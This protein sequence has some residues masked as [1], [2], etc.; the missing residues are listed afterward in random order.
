MW[1]ILLPDHS[2]KPATME[3]ANAQLAEW[4]KL[5]TY[6]QGHPKV[7]GKTDIGEIEV[8]TV[9]LMMDHNFMDEGPPL[10]FETMVF[11][12]PEEGDGYTERYATWNEAKEGHDRIVE[13]VRKEV[14]ERNKDA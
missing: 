4:S 14:E 2:T 13:A 1:Y 10:L 11:G 8:S 9:F 7:V 12:G 5:G 3:E 6:V